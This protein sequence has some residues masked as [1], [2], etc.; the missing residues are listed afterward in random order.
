MASLSTTSPPESSIQ[1]EIFGTDAAY[2]C[3]MLAP[4]KQMCNTRFEM[5]I[6]DK[7]FWDYPFTDWTMD[8]GVALA[9]TTSTM[10]KKHTLPKQLKH[11]SLGI[12]DEPTS[13]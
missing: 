2:I 4:P 1:G 10:K 5:T 7:L 6:Q 8:S 13:Y 3:E 12:C 11:V 9:T